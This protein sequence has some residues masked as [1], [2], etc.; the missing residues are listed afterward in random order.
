MTRALLVAEQLQPAAA[1]EAPF[2]GF[3]HRSGIRAAVEELRIPACRRFD[4]LHRNACQYILYV[5]HKH[6]FVT[7]LLRVTRRIAERS[8]QATAERYAGSEHMST[9]VSDHAHIISMHPQPL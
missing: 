1:L 5:G 6:S 9:R 7:H 2:R 4:V 3:G 8:A